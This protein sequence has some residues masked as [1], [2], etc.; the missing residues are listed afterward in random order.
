MLGLRAV[1][2]STPAFAPFF[3]PLLQEKLDSD[4]TSAKL[5]SL[6]TLVSECLGVGVGRYVLVNCRDNVTSSIFCL[7]SFGVIV[8]HPDPTNVLISSLNLIL[9]WLSPQ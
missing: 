1:L 4:L 8:F 2:A 7:S 3:L 5:D 9:C 6:H